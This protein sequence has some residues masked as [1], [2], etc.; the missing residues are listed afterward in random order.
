MIKKSEYGF[1]YKREFDNL[2]KYLHEV[3][4]IYLR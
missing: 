3:R 1:E 4:S 2:R